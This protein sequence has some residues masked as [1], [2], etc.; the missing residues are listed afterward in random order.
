MINLITP[1]DCYTG[2]GITGYN[3]WKNLYKL[4][5]ALALFLMHQPNLESEWNAKD[6]RQCVTN[7]INFNPDSPCF[8][9]WHAHELFLKTCGN[10]KYGALSFFEI[11]HCS[12]L[13]TIGY[14]LLDI[15]FMPSTWAKTVLENNGIKKPIV[16][17]PQGVDTAIFNA[18]IPTDKDDRKYVFINIGKWEIRKGHDIL[19]D[20]F[21][22]AFEHTDNVELWMINH[23][24]F[25]NSEKN[26]EWAKFYTGSKLGDKVR[27]FPRLPTQQHLAKAMSYAD[28]GLFPSRA[29]G[30]NNEAIELFAM[31]KPIIITD[32]SAH[33][34]YCNKDNA[35]LI[36][37]D[38][39]TPANDGIWFK[40]EG[41]WALIGD[42]QIEQTIE[43]MRFVY[44]NNIR[45]NLNGLLTARHYSWDKT[46]KIIY[47]NML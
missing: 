45:T 43:H 11:D 39:I 4:D 1:I 18:S 21:N 8:K 15:I 14:N 30:W 34:E 3:I 28:C 31:N 25:L 44:K 9:L 36:N 20:M 22:A 24:G 33:T 5:N 38:K 35:Y 26:A 42:E 10:S 19:I 7:Q 46:A 27:I 17:C 23:N 29:E 40:G 37:V 47:D 32:Y 6:I 13:E 41:N 16:V 2:Y 12:K